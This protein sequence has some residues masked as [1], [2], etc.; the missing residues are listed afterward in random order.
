V[1]GR[2]ESVMDLVDDDGR[3]EWEKDKPLSERLKVNK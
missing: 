1:G 2:V 3:K